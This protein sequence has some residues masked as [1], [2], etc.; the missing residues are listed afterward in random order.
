M[1]R[2]IVIPESFDD[3]TLGE[4]QKLSALKGDEEFITAKTI[5]VLTK[6]RADEAIRMKAKDRNAIIQDLN[7]ALSAQPSKLIRTFELDGKMFGFVPKLDDL[8]YGEFVDVDSYAVGSEDNRFENWHKLMAVLYRPITK[9]KGELYDIEPY[10]GSSKY[11]ELMKEA[12]SS[13]AFGVSVFFYAIGKDLLSSSLKSL[14]E[15]MPQMIKSVDSVENGAGIL[16][17]QRWLEATLQS[18]TSSLSIT[19]N[20]AL[21]SLRIT[22]INMN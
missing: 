10:E 14:A 4:F 22:W 20:N 12:P 3:I 15:E 9:M 13:V 1:K 19:I 8:T 16:Q 6:I 17:Y 5:E 18:L 21:P 2:E 7:K 11:A